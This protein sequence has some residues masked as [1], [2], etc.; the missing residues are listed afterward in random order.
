MSSRVEAN[1]LLQGRGRYFSARRCTSVLVEGLVDGGIYIPRRNCRRR[2]V[3]RGLEN[4][5]SAIVLPL[6][7]T[8]FSDMEITGGGNNGES[9]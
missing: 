9:G 4:Q 7:V 1:R 8:Q 3:P 5:T 6:I 2:P